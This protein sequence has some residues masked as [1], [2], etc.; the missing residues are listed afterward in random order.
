MERVDRQMKNNVGRFR[1][2]IAVRPG[3]IIARARALKAIRHKI[4]TAVRVAVKVSHY[5]G[6]G[7]GTSKYRSRRHKRYVRRDAE[8]IC[9][10]AERAM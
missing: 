8:A 10:N 3:P 7:K 5:V 6:M 2:C 1:T 9:H 4:G